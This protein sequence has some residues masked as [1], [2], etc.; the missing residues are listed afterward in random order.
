L[1]GRVA[2][3]ACL[4]LAWAG[5]II[6]PDP[7]YGESGETSAG[8]DAVGGTASSDGGADESGETSDGVVL[9]CGEADRGPAPGD[10]CPAGCDSCEGG[11]CVFEC[12]QE[13]AC[14]N[15]IFDCPPGWACTVTCQEHEACQEATVICPPHHPCTVECEGDK[16]CASLD[17][18]CAGGPCDLSCGTHIKSC[19]KVT[20]LCGPN[21]S[22]VTCDAV[23]DGE[24]VVEQDPASS[25]S[26]TAD[27]AC[28]EAP[29]AD[30]DTGD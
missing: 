23:I 3:I 8:R 7:D 27:A 6:V 13:R 4:A 18:V 25:C 11:V 21:T 14:R 2:A 16:A 1:I 19:E 28:T 17:L 24:F 5:C 29:P 9:E 30:D 10:P 15:E 26:C 20:V 12:L 22:T